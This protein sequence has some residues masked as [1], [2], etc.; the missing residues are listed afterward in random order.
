[1]C[2][3]SKAVVSGLLLCNLQQPDALSR[4]LLGKPLRPRIHHA[5]SS[6]RFHSASDAGKTHDMLHLSLSRRIQEHVW[7]GYFATGAARSAIQRHAA[8]SGNGCIRLAHGLQSFS[9]TNT[10]V[11]C[12][13]MS[14]AGSSSNCWC[15]PTPSTNEKNIPEG[16]LDILLPFFLIPSPFVTPCR[17]VAFCIQ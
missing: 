11:S 13:E 3:F 6:G 9:I 10:S 7:L 2:W 1:M 14:C 4:L 15:P 16:S 12:T 5:P 17:V 8:L